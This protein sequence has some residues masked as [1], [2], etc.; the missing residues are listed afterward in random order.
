MGLHMLIDL[1]CK[2]NKIKR[3]VNMLYL[4]SLPVS[5][6]YTFNCLHFLL[7]KGTII[8]KLIQ[9]SSMGGEGNMATACHNFMLIFQNNRDKSV[10]EA[11]SKLCRRILCSPHIRICCLCLRPRHFGC[12]FFR[13]INNEYIS[14]LW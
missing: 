10:V 3:Q 9:F 8:F 1:E 4:K 11:V 14:T 13:F 2:L 5:H 6:H 7:K 12:Q